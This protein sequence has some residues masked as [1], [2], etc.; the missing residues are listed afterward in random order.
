MMMMM[1]M[2]ILLD[3]LDLGMLRRGHTERLDSLKQFGRHG[4]FGVTAA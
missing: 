1:M 4:S 3:H 2:C